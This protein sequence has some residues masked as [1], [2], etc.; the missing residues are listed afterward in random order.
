MNATS[1]ASLRARLGLPTDSELTYAL[2]AADIADPFAGDDE[3][4]APEDRA[5]EWTESSADDADALRF[6][7]V[8]VIALALSTVAWVTL[9]AAAL[10]LATIL[11]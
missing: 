10:S 5:V 2:S 1:I 4:W 3:P 6:P 11:F 9:A 8:I 7:S